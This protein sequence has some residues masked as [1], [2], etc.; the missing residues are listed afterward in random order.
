MI[1]LSWLDRIEFRSLNQESSEP[2]DIGAEAPSRFVRSTI[3]WAAAGNGAFAA[4]VN[5]NC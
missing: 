5:F 4:E 2:G 1:I 3:I